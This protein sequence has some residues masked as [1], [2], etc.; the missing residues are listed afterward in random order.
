MPHVHQG[1]GG[2][3]DDLQHP[4]ADVGDGKGLVV[5]HVLAARLL[6][7]AH[8]VGLLIPPHELRGRAK[9]EDPEDE[10]HGEPDSADDGGVLIHL[11]QDVPQ[12]TPNYLILWVSG[13]P[14]KFLYI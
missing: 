2:D 5:A 12:E 11:L 9:D 14:T 4:E 7:V 1:R 13:L 3:E 6:G 8:E 10:K